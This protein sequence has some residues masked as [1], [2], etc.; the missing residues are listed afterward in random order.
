M[1]YSSFCPT[2]T[3]QISSHENL[4]MVIYVIGCPIQGE[5]IMTLLMDQDEVKY[6]V[7]TD[8][9]LVS[10][11]HAHVFANWCRSIGVHRFNAIILT[12]PDVDHCCGINHLV[13]EMDPKREAKLFLPAQIMT[14]MKISTDKVLSP[15]KTLLSKYSVKN[16]TLYLQ[17]FSKLRSP[18]ML[19][20]IF[21]A[22]LQRESTMTFIQMG[23]DDE[24]LFHQNLTE[25]KASHN[26]LSMVYTINYNDQNYLYCADMPGKYVNELD[27]EYLHNVRFVKIPHHG[28]KDCIGLSSQLM[29]NGETSVI[30]SSTVYHKLLDSCKLPH[31]EV[32]Q[33]YKLLGTAYCT[34]PKTEPMPLKTYRYGGIKINYSLSNGELYEKP[35]CQGNA[36]QY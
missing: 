22:A 19:E 8:C 36:Y 11:R 17:A 9:Y 12:H 32:M 28:S 33:K 18:I 31:K 6:S 23:T 13:D 3:L 26:D 30:S 14:V 2:E 5:M 35:I 1:I 16:K 34:G 10:R 4:R 20:I 29:K 24:F 27:E 21:Q 7:L 25:S 15:M